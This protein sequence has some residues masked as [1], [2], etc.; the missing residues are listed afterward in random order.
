M[1][2]WFMV[3]IIVD[4]EGWAQRKHAWMMLLNG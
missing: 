4:T 3:F 2:V 1:I